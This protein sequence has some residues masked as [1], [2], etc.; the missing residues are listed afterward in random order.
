[1]GQVTVPKELSITLNQ[2]RS[3]LTKEES[4]SVLVDKRYCFLSED[5]RDLSL[6]ENT[7]RVDEVYPSRSII[8]RPLP[9]KKCYNIHCEEEA[10]YKCQ[11]CGRVSYCSIRCMRN[12][13]PVHKKH[14]TK[15]P[16]R[17]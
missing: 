9:G 1:M 10:R 17:I 15:P 2:L 12:D 3:Y 14:C 11:D 7:S 4:L 16:W 8:I 5:F 6:H 13:Q